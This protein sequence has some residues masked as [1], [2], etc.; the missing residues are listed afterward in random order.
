M[1]TTLLFIGFLLF[2]TL[3]Y[4]Q[5]GADHRGTVLTVKNYLQTQGIETSG[6]CGAFQIT[7]RVA[8]TL[9]FEGI[10]LLD[11]PNGNNCQGYA[12]DA[13]TYKDG[14]HYDILIASG[15]EN[16]PAWNRIDGNVE[17]SRWRAPFD[18]NVSS[19]ELPQPP[20]PPTQPVPD[21]SALIQRVDIIEAQL[22]LAT[23]KVNELVEVI[24]T[25]TEKLTVLDAKVIPTSCRASILGI[26]I[27]CRLNP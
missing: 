13:L 4:A 7:K 8:W 24:N 5:Q 1:K 2:P 25:H 11:K 20:Q 16:I 21:L 15:E 6:P 19:P 22:R 14:E 26:P 27:S 9:R 23:A 17:L 3:G 12:V 18:P 10:G